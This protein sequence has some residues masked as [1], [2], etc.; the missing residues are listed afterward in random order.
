VTTKILGCPIPGCRDTRVNP[1]P[2]KARRRILLFDRTSRTER[3]VALTQ[4]LPCSGF[5][6][7]AIS[8]AEEIGVSAACRAMGIHRST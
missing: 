5:R 1:L 4:E 8:L 2:T 3:S 6:K 7:R